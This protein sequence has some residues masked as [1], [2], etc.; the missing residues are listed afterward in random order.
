MTDAA[1]PTGTVDGGHRLPGQGQQL[2]AERE[3][4]AQTAEHA[5]LM[6]E[7]RPADVPA[8]ADSVTL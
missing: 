2:A 8:L 1:R 5:L 3:K 4:R 7:A 6:L